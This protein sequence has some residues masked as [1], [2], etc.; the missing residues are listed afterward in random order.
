[1]PTLS[2]GMV[3]LNPYNSSPSDCIIGAICNKNKH[4]NALLV[5]KTILPCFL[6]CSNCLGRCTSAYSFKHSA[7]GGRHTHFHRPHR[8]TT[9]ATPQPQLASITQIKNKSNQQAKFHNKKLCQNILFT[10]ISFIS[11]S[12]KRVPCSKCRQTKA[13][14][15]KAVETTGTTAQNT[16]KQAKETKQSQRSKEI[17]RNFYFYLVNDRVPL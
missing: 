16:Y 9:F 13:L 5:N 10:L 6:G 2:L 8:H 15:C 17:T 14:E 11:P 1:M 12:G 3:L 7:V 4:K